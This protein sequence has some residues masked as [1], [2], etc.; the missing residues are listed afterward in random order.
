MKNRANIF[1]SFYDKNLEEEYADWREPSRRIQIRIISFLTG[2]LYLLY[3]QVDR[4]VADDEALSIMFLFHLCLLPAIAFTI[5]IFSFWKNLYNQM[6]FLLII[7]PMLAAIGNLLIVTSVENYVVYF[8]GLYLI[9]F[10]ALTISGLRLTHSLIS[11]IFIVVVSTLF[12][13]KIPNDIFVMH[14]FWM[15]SSLCFGFV[16]AYIFER[17]NK[18]V[19]LNY[20]ELEQ[21]A[22]TD[23]LTGLFNRTKFNEVVKNEV[24]RSKRFGHTFGLAIFDIDHFKSVNDNYGHQVGDKVLVE[25]VNIVKNNLRTTDM[26]FRWGGEEFIVIC[27]ETNKDGFRI[28]LENIRKTIE[29]NVFEDIDSKTVSIGFTMHEKSD[30]EMSLV[31]KADEALYKAKNSGRNRIEF[32]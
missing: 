17:L 3:Y 12:L 29:E 15:F 18:Q 1:L 30:D 7:A 25:I 9:V 13:Y 8:P 5:S 24:L 2:V 28:L 20:K 4:V 21:L 19:F 16:S 22:V 32:Q 31:E 14:L 27:L 23:S 6:I 26:F 11:V 10:W